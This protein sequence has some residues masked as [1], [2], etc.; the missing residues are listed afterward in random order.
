METAVI[1]SRMWGLRMVDLNICYVAAC[2]HQTMIAATASLPNAWLCGVP[3]H[4][5]GTSDNSHLLG[6]IG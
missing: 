6:E 4:S 3:E 1:H 5:A 2:H